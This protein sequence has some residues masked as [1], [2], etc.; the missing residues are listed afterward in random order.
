VKRVAEEMRGLA[1]ERDMCMVSAT[2]TNRSGFQ[3]SDFDMDAVADSFGLPMTVDFFLALISSEDL[4]QANQ[5]ECKQL[6]NR[7]GDKDKQRRFLLG[8][9]KSQMRFFM[10]DETLDLIDNVPD[11]G[12]SDRL[13]MLGV[14]EVVIPTGLE[15]T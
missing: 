12:L 4:A 8:V 6:K 9:E 5:L 1:V 15:L 13:A 2:Q 7:Y 14:P 11:L 3:S 10:P